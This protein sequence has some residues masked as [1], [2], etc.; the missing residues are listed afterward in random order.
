MFGKKK[1]LVFLSH[2]ASFPVVLGLRSNV[3]SPVALRKSYVDVNHTD[4][5][6]TLEFL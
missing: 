2:P 5:T 4:E 3:M 1:S 6:E